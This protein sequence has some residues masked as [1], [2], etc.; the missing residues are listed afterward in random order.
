MT[1]GVTTASV[2]EL[3]LPDY[4]V[5]YIQ[6]QLPQKVLTDMEKSNQAKA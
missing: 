6:L 3:V 4:G 2:K 1:L 5:C